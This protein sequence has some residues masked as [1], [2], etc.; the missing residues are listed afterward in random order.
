MNML[1]EYNVDSFTGF[2][3]DG[4]N[5]FIEEY[6]VYIDEFDL[7]K[8]EFGNVERYQLL[9]NYSKAVKDYYTTDTKE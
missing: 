1:K 7:F 5:Q 3:K 6:G 8:L 9:N 2:N 4:I